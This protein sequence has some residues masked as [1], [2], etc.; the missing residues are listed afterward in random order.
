MSEGTYDC[1]NLT[2]IFLNLQTKYQNVQPHKDLLLTWTL[3]EFL[4]IF[5]VP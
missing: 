5:A 3:H 1:P 2:I 4:F